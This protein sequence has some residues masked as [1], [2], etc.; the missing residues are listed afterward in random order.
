M[1]SLRSIL[2]ERSEYFFEILKYD[3]SEWLDFWKEYRTRKF[4]VVIPLYEK[5]H[6]LTNDEKLKNVLN[7]LSRPFLDKLHQRIKNEFRELKEKTVKEISKKGKE[8][9]LSKE[10]FHMMIIGLLGLKPYTLI[11]TPLK[12]TVVLLDPIGIEKEVGLDNFI[13]ISIEAAFKAKNFS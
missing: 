12:G 9:E 8:L 10:K 2:L 1:V 11:K 4:P 5:A 7:D 13:D 6:G 3:K